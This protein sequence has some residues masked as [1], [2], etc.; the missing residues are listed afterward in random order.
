MGGGASTNFDNVKHQVLTHLMNKPSD[1]SDIGTYEDAQEEL[2]TLR[3]LAKEFKY[4]LYDPSA[5][6]NGTSTS[7]PEAD[8]MKKKKRIPAILARD[9]NEARLVASTSYSPK[10]VDKPADITTFLTDIIHMS[11]LFQNCLPDELKAIV[12]AFEMIEVV[13]GTTI[14]QQGDRGDHFYIIEKGLCSAW[15]TNTK[16]GSEGEGIRQ[17]SGPEMGPS[18]TFGELA[19]MYNSPRAADV[20][21]DKDV[22]LWKIGRQDYKEILVHFKHKRIK[23]NVDFLRNIQVNDRKLGTNLSSSQLEYLALA[24]EREVFDVGDVILRQGSHG[25]HFYIIENGAVGVFKE[26]GGELEK[27]N[28]LSRGDYFGE[29]ALLNE[30]LRQATVIADTH[31]ECLTMSRQVFDSLV[32]SLE[33]AVALTSKKA[34]EG[35]KSATTTTETKTDKELEDEALS[36]MYQ[37]VTSFGMT[38]FEPV[39]IIG[40]GTFGVIRVCKF[41]AEDPT[42]PTDKAYVLKSQPKALLVERGLEEH[43]VVEVNIMLLCTSSNFVVDLYGV[44]QDEYNIHYVMEYLPGGELYKYMLARSMLEHTTVRFYAACFVEGLK[45]L[46]ASNIAYRDTK[47][48]NLCLDRRGYLKIVDFGMAKRLTENKT[49]TICGTPEFIAPEVLLLEGHNHAVDYWGTGILIFE[50]LTGATPFEDEDDNPSKVYEN[51]LGAINLEAKFKKIF[52]KDTV[53]L[54]RKLLSPQAKRLGNTKKGVQGIMNH[55]YFNNINFK[56]LEAGKI[57]APYVPVVESMDDTRNFDVFDEPEPVQ[58]S[59]WE[60]DFTVY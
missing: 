17:R 51:I 13:A 20:V 33:D 47:P 29:L 35:L 12:A 54:L 21:A 57:R 32:G 55:K 30:D 23:Q 8:A 7:N 4:M 10:V 44:F 24:L 22:V 11:V 1:L 52:N 36:K 42:L 46:H 9:K 16:K 31:V 6:V 34:E 18:D 48:E 14:I 41:V 26:K 50:M 37:P 49:W 15:V 56:A 43:S 2:K 38:D 45:A 58:K 59:E 28:S 40:H 60:V 3:H 27:V 39:K 5:Q 53:D 25:D 19:L